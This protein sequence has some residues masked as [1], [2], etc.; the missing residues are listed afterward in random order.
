[1]S[2]VPP[3]AVGYAV[4][5]HRASPTA[6]SRHCP[7]TPA[8]RA[9]ACDGAERSALGAGA[10]ARRLACR[11]AVM[12]WITPPIASRAVE[13]G[14]LAAQHLDPRVDRRRSAC[15]KSILA[16]DR[17]RRPRSRRSARG[18]GCPRAPR[19][20]TWVRPPTSPARLTATPGTSRST[21]ETT[22]VWRCFDRCGVEHGDRRA[23]ARRRPCRS[24]ER[25]AV[26]TIGRRRS[27]RRRSA[28]GSL[29][30][31][32]GVARRRAPAEKR[33]MVFIHGQPPASVRRQ[34]RG[35]TRSATGRSDGGGRTH[36]PARHAHR[37]GPSRM[38]VARTDEFRASAI[39]LG[40][41]MSDQRRQVSWL[42]GHGSMHAFPGSWPQ[43]LP[44][45][46]VRTGASRSPLTVAGTA[47][48]SGRTPHRIPF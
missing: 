32:A 44:P 3:R 31:S 21:S 38:V 2:R 33:R 27:R 43:W 37:C 17:D 28:I 9:R 35:R 25:E 23:A 4:G 36:A 22:R 34:R 8:A 18:R 20:R 29:C 5:A 14:L 26:T 11:S 6:H 13:R 41:G 39:S 15:R 42:A 48:D 12:Y 10:E 46:Q 45:G 24:P 7:A 30:A 19:T 47:A 1:M 16:L 40:R